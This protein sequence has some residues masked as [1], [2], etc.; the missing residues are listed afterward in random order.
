MRRQAE[1]VRL[2]R[3]PGGEVEPDVARRRGGRGAYVC[4]RPECLDGAVRRQAFG[5]AFRS[6]A[7]LAPGVIEAVRRIVDGPGLAGAVDV[8]SAK[9]GR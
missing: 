4:Q 9:G 1:L 6:P 2:V 3:G 5:H 8:L 7:R